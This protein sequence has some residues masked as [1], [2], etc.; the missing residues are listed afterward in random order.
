MAK[1]FFDKLNKNPSVEAK[2]SGLIMPVYYSREQQNK[3]I[4]P[5]GIKIEGNPVPLDEAL[6]NWPDKI[7]VIGSDVPAQIFEVINE[8]SS[9]MDKRDV[10][11][12]HFSDI[13]QKDSSYMEK[14]RDLTQQIL[15][16]VNVLVEE[17]KG[18]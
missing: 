14:S 9:N 1:L 16:K 15:D 10:S 3:A 12:W 4:E 11:V 2:A 6:F 13:G 7:I 8:K 5:F 18:A 17:L